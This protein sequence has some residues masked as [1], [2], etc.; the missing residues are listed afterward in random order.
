MSS[1]LFVLHWITDFTSKGRI[2]RDMA[3]SYSSQKSTIAT[4]HVLDF[5]LP[6]GVV[7]IVQRSKCPHALDRGSILIFVAVQSS[8]NHFSPQRT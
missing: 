5:V 2:V 7:V 4:R 8:H 3:T 6:V 1:S